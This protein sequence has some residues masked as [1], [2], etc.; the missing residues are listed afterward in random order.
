M[1]LSSREEGSPRPTL[2]WHIIDACNYACE[3]CCEKRY[4]KMMPSMGIA[5]DETVEKVLEEIR[6]LEGSWL[7]RFTSGEPTLHPKFPY[8]CGEIAKTRHT[9]SLTTNFSQPKEKLAGLLKACGNKLARLTPTLHPSQANVG[10]FIE[11]AIWVNSIKDP[12][13]KLIV[14]S[15]AT[16]RNF[17]ELK[18][19]EKTLSSNNIIFNYIVLRLSDGQSASYPKHMEEYLAPRLEKHMKRFRTPSFFGRQCYA[20]DKYLIIKVNG[21]VF[22]CAETQFFGYLGN[23]PRGTFHRNEGP[24]VCLSP[25]CTCTIP[26]RHGMILEE[27]E[28][29]VKIGYLLGKGFINEKNLRKGAIKYPI[30]KI[31][32]KFMQ[33]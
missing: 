16:E 26:S 6:N 25:I 30:K 21:D 23:I 13:T 17:E 3:Y 28:N 11:K 20:G 14:S 22:R 19:V 31:K 7:I 32:G 9:I 2:E 24:R 4:D 5:G 29:F 33:G 15:V 8:I 27:K 1:E 10:E 12:N 18:R